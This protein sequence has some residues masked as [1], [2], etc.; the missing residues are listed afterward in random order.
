MVLFYSAVTVFSI[1]ISLRAKRA[2]IQKNLQTFC[3]Y[4][5][6]FAS[7]IH[8]DNMIRLST[9][10]R[11][12]QVSRP[13]LKNKSVISIQQKINSQIEQQIRISGR[14]CNPRIL[15]QQSFA[16][17]IISLFVAAPLIVVSSIFVN[18]YVFLILPLCGIWLFYPKIKLW[19]VVSER[20]SSLDDE[21]AFF[22]LY[23]SVLQSTGQ[24]L[25]DSI[26]DV[27]GKGIFPSLESEGKMLL[28]NVRIFGMDQITALNEHGYLHPNFGFGNLL[29][30]Y[31]SINKSG[32]NLTLYMER[33][34]EEFFNKTQ[35]KYANYR[36]QAQLIGETIL[37]LLTILPTMILVSSFMLAENSVRTVMSLAF[38]LI[39]MMTIFI[40][41]LICLSQ[42]KVRNVVDFDFK[43]IFFGAFASI[44]SLLLG[45]EPW[46]VVGIGVTIGAIF[47]FIV[48]LKQFRNIALI[49]SALP[50]FF[51]DI[52]EYRKI[53]IPIPN[54]IIKIAD[55]RTYNKYFDDL[56]SVISIR[57]KYGLNLSEVLDSVLIRSWVAK[58]AFFVLGKVAYSGGGT[59][60]ILEQITNFTTNINQAK[61]ETHASIGIMSYFAFLSPVMMTY[62]TKEMTIVLERLDSGLNGMIQSAFSIEAMLVSDELI[63]AINLLNVLSAISIGIVMSKLS[64]FSMKYTLN[65]GIAVLISILSIMASPL[66]PSFVQI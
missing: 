26:I 53:G 54:A 17:M 32:G 23:A 61:K 18:P 57:L 58:T 49:E 8:S 55:G 52:T 40:I 13:L 6:F 12:L 16:Y 50:D 1:L 20:K 66:F 39:P 59:A 45:Q 34:S 46:F 33:K 10:N 60:Q 44:A 9:N 47:N 30:G 48:C 36:N 41:L 28:R 25:Y 38:V 3:I 15:M 62:T 11:I 19:F 31:A 64:H 56:L 24:S 51:R 2:S 27:I 42:P 29:L 21:M 5:K 35:F 63:G 43:S 7:K 4:L 14:A 37:I 65:L 22:T